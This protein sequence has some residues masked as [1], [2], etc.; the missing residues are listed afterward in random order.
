MD[1]THLVRDQGGIEEVPVS[2]EFGGRQQRV[3]VR[4]SP[5]A[6]LVVPAGHISGRDVVR[7]HVA[8]LSSDGQG[9]SYAFDYVGDVVWMSQEL[10]INVGRD[11]RIS[12]V[13]REN[14]G[15]FWL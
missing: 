15:A 1:S 8:H 5:T 3:F 12:R 2:V 14:S 6:A 9:K 11:V 7:Q 13:D 10:R 4:Y